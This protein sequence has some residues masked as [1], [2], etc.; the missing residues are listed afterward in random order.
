LPRQDRILVI[1][2]PLALHVSRTQHREAS[3]IHRFSRAS[4][5]GSIGAQ[6]SIRVQLGDSVQKNSSSRSVPWMRLGCPKRW[7]QRA[8]LSTFRLHRR[9]G[10]YS[11]VYTEAELLDIVRRIESKPRENMC[12]SAMIM[13]YF[14]TVASSLKS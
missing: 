11:H 1:P 13:V 6:T 10:W 3:E 12:I 8:T 4:R 2:V 7:P 5:K 14:Q 9:T